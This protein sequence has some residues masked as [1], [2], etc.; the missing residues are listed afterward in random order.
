MEEYKNALKYK[1]KNYDDYI[2]CLTASAD[3]GWRDAIQELENE[4]INGSKI[5]TQYYKVTLKFYE[6]RHGQY[7]RF[8]MAEYYHHTKYDYKKAMSL[9]VE[10][11]EEQFGQAI[12]AIGFMYLRGQGV[13]RDYKMAVKYFKMSKYGYNNLGYMYQEGFGVKANMDT[14]IKYYKLAIEDKN[15]NGI[16]NLVQVYMRYRVS[17]DEII[18]YFIKIGKKSEL[19]KIFSPDKLLD[20]FLNLRKENTEMKNHILASPEGLLYFEA[21]SS[22]KHDIQN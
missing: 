18:E 4:Y 11:A 12:N 6:E 8:A 13:V 10:L 19:R 17:D 2:M 7:S 21:L 16:D 9:Y 3:E 22:W 1:G 20:M 14:A 5:P 15:L